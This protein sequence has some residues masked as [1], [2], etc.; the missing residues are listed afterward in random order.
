MIDLHCG[1]CLDILPTLEPN[2]IDT[3]ISDPPYFGIVGH[4]WDKAWSSI[5]DWVDY[6]LCIFREVKRVLKPQGSLYVFGDDKNIAYLQVALDKV[7]T[8]LNSLV[9]F[10][11]TICP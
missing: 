5:D 7:F 6:L 1:D 2:S 10:K 11:T 8:F 3:C 4:D 9:W